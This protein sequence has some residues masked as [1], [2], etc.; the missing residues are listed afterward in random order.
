MVYMTSRKTPFNSSLLG[1]IY[2]CTYE[3]EKS[4]YEISNQIYGY[5]KKAHQILEIIRERHDCFKKV[6]KK[7]WKYPRYISKVNPLVNEICEGLE[8]DANSK[9]KFRSL[10]NSQPFRNNIVY[11]KMVRNTNDILLF[12]SII[13]SSV[14]VLNH[15]YYDKV[16]EYKKLNFTMDNVHNITKRAEIEYRK[17]IPSISE[18]TSVIDFIGTGQKIGETLRTFPSDIIDHLISLSPLAFLIPKTTIAVLTVNDAL[19]EYKLSQ[20]N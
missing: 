14:Y 16:S 2:T 3:K 4:G 6:E 1:K 8:I 5:D 11:D 10:F 20:K 18:D 17:H 9:R 7:D 13:A 15:Y 19:W 12:I